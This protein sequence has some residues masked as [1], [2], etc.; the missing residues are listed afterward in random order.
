MGVD[1]TDAF[2]VVRW[3]DAAGLPRYSFVTPPHLREVQAEVLQV[4]SCSS[5]QEAAAIVAR[6]NAGSS[7]SPG[8]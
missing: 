6:L 4:E 8:S 1:I 3:P 5:I 2:I 7:P